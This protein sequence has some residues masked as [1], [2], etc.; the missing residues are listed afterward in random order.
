[1]MFGLQSFIM[2][3][4]SQFGSIFGRHITY[5]AISI[6]V[7]QNHQSASSIALGTAFTQAVLILVGPF[8]GRFADTKERKKLLVIADIG[9][10]G[11]LLLLASYIGYQ[12]EPSLIVIYSLLLLG[13]IVDSVHYPA[14]VSSIPQLVKKEQLVK[15]NSLISLS[16]STSLLFTP[17]IAVFLLSIFSIY[18]ILIINTVA[19]LFAL[20]CLTF[21]QFPHFSSTEKKQTNVWADLKHAFTFLKNFPGAFY[22]TC[23]NSSVNFCI[24]AAFILVTPFILSVSEGDNMLLGTLLAIGGGAQILVS[25]MATLIPNPKHPFRASMIAATLLGMGIIVLGIARQP[26]FWGLGLCVFM[27]LIP[28]INATNRSIWQNAIPTE[29]QGRFFAVR[30]ALSRASTPIAQAFSGLLVDYVIQPYFSE[31]I[32]ISYN[33]AITCFGVLLAVIAINAYTF[34]AVVPEKI[35]NPNRT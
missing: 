14:L 8:A 28:Y 4:I 24:V 6:W 2:L 15:A 10:I 25:L 22:I 26:F 29:M 16:D 33:I 11:S 12:S 17:L 1:M 23:I 27:G 13:G 18:T 35:E 5:F 34:V 21:V 19:H 30:R 3:W 20:F 31:P 9:Q 32:G 7:F